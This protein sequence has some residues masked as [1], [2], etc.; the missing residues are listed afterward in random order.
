MIFTPDVS[1]CAPSLPLSL[2][3]THTHHPIELNLVCIFAPDHS[4]PQVDCSSPHLHHPYPQHMMWRRRAEGGCRQ[5][6]SVCSAGHSAASSDSTRQPFPSFAHCGC[7]RNAGCAASLAE[8]PTQ[9]LHS[10]FDQITQQREWGERERR[11]M[12]LSN[13]ALPPRIK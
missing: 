1:C 3:L 4:D 6:R 11:G 5:P 8:P 2:S 10:C 13:S 7:K 12:K 9:T